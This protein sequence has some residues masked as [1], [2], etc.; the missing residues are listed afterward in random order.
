MH[1]FLTKGGKENRIWSHATFDAPVLDATFRAVD[2]VLP[3]HYRDNRDLRTLFDGLELTE[4]KRGHPL[5]HT[6]GWDAFAQGQ[7]VLEALKIKET[8]RLWIAASDLVKTSEE[9]T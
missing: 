9:G 4:L 1:L 7:Q 3:W 8:Y 5:E 2:K 6:C